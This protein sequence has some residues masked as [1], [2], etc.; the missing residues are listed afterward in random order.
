MEKE[1]NFNGDPYIKIV[2]LLFG[3]IINSKNLLTD[4]GKVFMV[5]LF[6]T[7]GFQKEMDWLTWKQIK[8]YTGIKHKQ[9]IHRSIKKLKNKNQITKDGKY[10][11]VNQNFEKW[12]SLDNEN[13]ELIKESYQYKKSSNMI[14]IDNKKSSNMITE[15]IKSD[16]SKVSNMITPSTDKT[17]TDKTITDNKYIYSPDDPVNNFYNE[18]KDKEDKKQIEQIEEIIIYLNSKADK[19]FRFNNKNT[20]KEIKARLND[21]YNIADCKKVIDIKTSQW[22]NTEYDKYLRPK[23]LFGNKFEDYLNEKIIEVIKGGEYGK[24]IKHFEN[25]RDYTD[26]ERQQIEAKFYS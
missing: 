20:I 18:G 17:I 24:P 1:N 23:T 2:N 22:K 3:A 10:F 21:G 13:I 7:I 11:K 12:L 16:Y 4:E 15:I 14:T 6:K 8:N 26:E 9:N 25:E 5:I 19:N